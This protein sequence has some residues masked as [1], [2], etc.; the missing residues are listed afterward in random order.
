MKNLNQKREKAISVVKIYFFLNASSSLLGFLKI[1]PSKKTD[2]CRMW[3]W[4]LCRKHVGTGG[5]SKWHETYVPVLSVPK[6]IPN[7]DSCSGT[8]QSFDTR[9]YQ[10][11]TTYKL[12]SAKKC[13]HLTLC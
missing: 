12:I 3:L 10:L 1:T 11:Q 6:G 7:K 5:C 9:A 4:S 8:R 2:T 13:K